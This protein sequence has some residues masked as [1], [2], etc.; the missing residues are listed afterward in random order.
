[1]RSTPYVQIDSKI[2]ARNLKN[3][4]G[5]IQQ[6]NKDVV[7]RPH[8][9]THKMPEFAQMQ[10]AA[11]GVGIT[12]AK[13]SEAEIMADAGIQDI[14]IAYPVVT[15][16]K[17]KRL[18]A[19]QKQLTRLIVSVDSVEGVA[20]LSQIAQDAET[21]FEARVEVNT[22]LN[23]TGLLPQDVAAFCQ[24]VQTN[25]PGVVISGIY[26]FRGAMLGG[27]ATADINS[28]GI[29]EGTIMVELAKAL[30][31]E[32]I[33]IDDVSVGSTQT[34]VAAAQVA[35]VTEVR[36]GTY[37]FHD[38]MQIAFGLAEV[39]DCAAAVKVTVVSVPDN[40]RAII[41][42]GS[43]TFATD[44]QPVDGHIRIVGFGYVKEH[45]EIIFER[46]N[47]EHGI[48]S[49]H[50]AD[51]KVGDILTIIPNHICSTINLHTTVM[52]DAKELTVAARGA[53]V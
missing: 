44:V 30:R 41:D 52:L 5:K 39:S 3:V 23:R 17:G 20:M 4:H 1:M 35:G 2:V 33:A 9:K 48:L 50:G 38:V 40:E 28:A 11:G 31:A 21:V 13:I 34:G 24:M 49:L 36:I 10:L 51:V 45:P 53:L 12:T 14:F 7:I 42:G 46:M 16:E 6:M 15:A 19:L 29:E 32:G 27:V 37:I 26:T 8:I 18:L 43:K 47:E 22:G 25:Y